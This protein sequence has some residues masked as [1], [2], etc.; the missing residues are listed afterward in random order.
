MKNSKIMGIYF[1]LIAMFQMLFGYYDKD[2][3]FIAMVI[4]FSFGVLI[5]TIEECKS[6]TPYELNN[7]FQRKQD[8]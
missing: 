7:D 1:L 8:G 2:T 6:L 3:Y 5:K 4:I